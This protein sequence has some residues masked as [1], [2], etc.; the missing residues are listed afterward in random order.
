MKLPVAMPL[1]VAM[2]LGVMGQVRG[3]TPAQSATQTGTSPCQVEAL[4]GDWHEFS[5][6]AG[7]SAAVR[8]MRFGVLLSGGHDDSSSS[9]AVRLGAVELP[10]D[11]DS[12]TSSEGEYGD[13]NLA[14]RFKLPAA[15]PGSSN[16][17]TVSLKASHVRLERYTLTTE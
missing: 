12:K 4:P 16:K 8:T 15:Q 14:C 17:L 5:C 7:A 9:L 3:Q 10:C 1:V 2:V 13:I 6:D 11:K